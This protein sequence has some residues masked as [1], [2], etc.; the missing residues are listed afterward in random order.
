V[1]TAELVSGATVGDDL[2]DIGVSTGDSAGT[3]AVRGLSG[4]L[5]AVTFVD[6]NAGDIV[7]SAPVTSGTATLSLPKQSSRTL[8]LSTVLPEIEDG[9][10]DGATITPGETVTPTAD[11]SH[12]TF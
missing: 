12:Q 4:S 7:D 1:T 6:A 2:S 5:D 11:I 3:V 9:S 8:A 10:P